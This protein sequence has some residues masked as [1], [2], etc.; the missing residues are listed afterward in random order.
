MK[1][2]F[3]LAFATLLLLSSCGNDDNENNQNVIKPI[4]GSWKMSKT[5]MISGANNAILQSSPVSGCEA[6]NTFEFGQNQ[7]FSIKYYTKNNMECITDG[8]DTG[9]YQYSENSKMLT[10]TYSDSMVK[11]VV[12]Y[13]IDSA[14]IMTVDHIE[15]YN[16]DGVNDTSVILFK[17]QQ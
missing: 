16:D 4:V 13:S 10:F 3:L 1:K 15:D 8:F 7:S 5:M 2:N 11:S 12:V 9:T 6:L 17:K 14:E